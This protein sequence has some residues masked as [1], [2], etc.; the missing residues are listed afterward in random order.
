MSQKYL[1]HK[2]KIKAGDV[3]YHKDLLPEDALKEEVSGGGW[4]HHDTEQKDGKTINIITF[5]NLSTDFGPVEK[6]TLSEI[7]CCTDYPNEWTGFKF[8]YIPWKYRPENIGD[9]TNIIQYR[10]EI[11]LYSEL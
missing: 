5:Y 1:I 7:L 9:P 3:D 11:R 10:E 2:N 4:Y 8:Y 6:E